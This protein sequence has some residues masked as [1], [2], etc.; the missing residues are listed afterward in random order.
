MTAVA[1]FALSIG[2]VPIAPSEILAMI[3]RHPGASAEHEAVF[4]AIRAPRVLLGLLVGAGL[5]MSGAAMQ[6]IFRNPLVDPGL[7]GVSSGAALGAV[8]AIVL[9]ARAAGA[10]PP[11]VAGHLVALAAF[12][13]ALG[14]MTLVQRF[15]GGGGRAAVTTLLLA[16]IAINALAGALTGVVTFLANDAQLRTLTFWSFGSLGAATWKTSLATAPFVVLPLV[17]LPRLARPLDALLL[18]DDEAGHVGFSVERTKRVVLAMSA[19]AVGAAVAVAGIIAFVGLVVPHLARLALGA[20]HRTLLP[21]SAALGA[22]LLLVADVVARTAASPAELPL[23]MLTAI[24]GTPLFLA[25]LARE[26]RRLA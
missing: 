13:G 3:A 9:G 10:L 18:G 25:L 24:M 19:L 14:A 21:A 1:F 5:G 23:G 11:S 8:S 4:F 6:G 17:V 2:S 20:R 12:G 7:L 22:T 15:A 26:R 16:G